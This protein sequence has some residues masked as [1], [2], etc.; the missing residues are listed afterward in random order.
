MF[1]HTNDS[2][3]IPIG[4]IVAMHRVPVFRHFSTPWVSTVVPIVRDSGGVPIIPHPDAQPMRQYLH[5]NTS[6]LTTVADSAPILKL[7]E[8]K[9]NK[10]STFRKGL[11][12]RL[13]LVRMVE[14]E[15]IKVVEKE[16]AAYARLLKRE[17]ELR[18]FEALD[19]PTA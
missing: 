17:E 14:E 11:P 6:F 1:F 8:L 16:E 18:K 15:R 12:S 5:N 13:E 9:R 19:A 10:M 3:Y 4:D 2:I 7:S